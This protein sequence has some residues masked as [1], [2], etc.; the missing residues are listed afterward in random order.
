MLLVKGARSWISPS[1]EQKL[2]GSEDLAISVVVRHDHPV[3]PHNRRRHFVL[4]RSASLAICSNSMSVN[5]SQ[6]GL[7]PAS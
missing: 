4:Y 1:S 7:W 3:E 6:L 5:A 2:I